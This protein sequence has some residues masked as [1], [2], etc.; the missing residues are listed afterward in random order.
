MIYL[1]NDEAASTRYLKELIPCGYY[2][3]LW[4]ATAR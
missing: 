1:S 2:I 3:N 4:E